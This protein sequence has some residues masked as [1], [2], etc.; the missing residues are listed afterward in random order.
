MTAEIGKVL[1]IQEI[2]A[3]KPN[4][5]A[6]LA[7]GCAVTIA[8]A[9]GT[10]AGLVI[11]AAVIAQAGHR[12]PDS[13]IY[14]PLYAATTSLLVVTLRWGL[15]EWRSFRLRQAATEA[16]WTAYH[17]R[18]EGA[19]SLV[20]L[21]IAAAENAIHRDING[22]LSAFA[23]ADGVIGVPQPPRPQ[24]YATLRAMDGKPRPLLLESAAKA[25]TPATAPPAASRPACAGH[26]DLSASA[27]AGRRLI[28][29]G[30]TEITDADLVAVIERLYQVGIARG[31]WA[32]SRL[33]SG[34]TISKDEHAAI[35]SGLAQLGII[36]GRRERVTG[37]LAY[38][39]A[40]AALA[41]LALARPDQARARQERPI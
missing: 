27:Q 5:R 17:H 21:T 13:A 26:A 33:P 31:R 1:T 36:T 32:G 41:A 12:L 16:T 39:T 7:A 14:W 4:W 8:S 15:A 37:R 19:V 18:A 23:Q 29:P 22:D 3:L 20:D 28:L 35:M 10:T 30:N 34:R 38:P 25:A 6:A 40:D 24:R 2:E 11:V 9:I